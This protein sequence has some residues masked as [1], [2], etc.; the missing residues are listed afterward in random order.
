MRFLSYARMGRTW[1]PVDAAVGAAPA[2]A[3]A[4]AEA[5]V[6]GPSLEVGPDHSGAPSEQ[7]SLPPSPK[8]K[9]AQRTR[10]GKKASPTTALRNHQSRRQMAAEATYGG[11]GSS[12]LVGRR[13]NRLGSS[14]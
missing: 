7:G 8:D 6:E 3:P 11:D 13:Q 12:P 9:G 5:G 4:A 14:P 1:P 10:F 2:A